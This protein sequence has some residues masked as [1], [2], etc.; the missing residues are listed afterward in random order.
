MPSTATVAVA[1]AV[2]VPP[3]LTR[4][5]AAVRTEWGEAWAPLQARTTWT[6]SSPI[7]SPRTRYVMVVPVSEVPQAGELVYF[8]G[9]SIFFVGG[10]FLFLR[11][12]CRIDW[13]VVAESWGCV[14]G[15]GLVCL[16]LKH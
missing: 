16:F 14:T 5:A 2:A 3:V 9:M 4:L 12:L 7:W 15:L 13:R 11:R 1:V 6:A 8:V 10:Q